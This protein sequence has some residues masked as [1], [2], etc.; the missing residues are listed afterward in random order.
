M[1]SLA[2]HV[3]GVIEGLLKSPGF[4][5]IVVDLLL[6]YKSRIDSIIYIRLEIAEETFVSIS[7]CKHND[8]PSKIIHNKLL[9]P[10]S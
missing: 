4:R 7:K 1:G 3:N 9:V 6:P 10:D 8:N 5:V 2:R